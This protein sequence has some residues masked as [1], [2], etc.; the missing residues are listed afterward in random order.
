MVLVFVSI[1]QLSAAMGLTKQYLRFEAGPVFGVIGSRDC[2]ICWLEL[3]KVSRRYVAAAACEKVCVW[4]TVTGERLM[5]LHGGDSEVTCLAAH[6]ARALLAA[7][8][9]D[10]SV[11]LFSLSSGDLRVTL[12]GHRS[13]VSSVNFDSAGMRLVSGGKDNEIVVWD[14][15]V[16]AGLYRLLGHKGAVTQVRFMHQHNCLVSSSKDTY[17]KFWDLDNQHCFKTLAGHLTEVWDFVLTENDSRLVTGSGDAEL[18]VYTLQFTEGDDEPPAKAA[19]EAPADGDED[20]LE[21]DRSN[22]ECVRLGSIVRQGKGRVSRMVI[23]R[24]CRLVGFH[25]NDNTLELF[26]LNTEDDIA[27]RRQKRIKK[28]QKRAREAGKE[29]TPATQALQDELRRLPSIN[30]PSKVKAVDVSLDGQQAKLTVLLANNSLAVY[31][32]RVEA[33]SDGAVV[34][35]GSQLLLPGHRSE[36]RALD[37]S[38]DGTALLS[39]SSEQLKVWNRSTHQCIRTL[40]CDPALAALFVPGDRHVL[41]AGKSG[42][43]QLLELASGAL[44]ENVTAHG[45]EIWGMALTPDKRGFATA[46]AD[47]QV[48]LWRF[49]LVSTEQDRRRLSFLH[50]ASHTLSDDCL[51]I[52]FSPDGRLL[53]V[54]LLDSTVQIFFT[55]TMKLFLSLYGHRLPVLCMDISH[56]STLIA[57]GSGDRNVKIWGL[58]FGDCHKSL[59]AHDDSVTGLKFVPR[60]HHFFTCG[61]D[62]QVKEWDADSHQRIQTLQ[63][64]C[65]EVLALAVSP[66]GRHVLSSS[67]DRSLRLWQKTDEPLVLE[68]EREE[69]RAKEEERRLATGPAAAVPGETD[70]EAGRAGHKTADT[71]RAAE[72]L[73]EGITIYKQ[74]SR[75]LRQ[76]STAE[77]HPLMLAYGCSTPDAFMAEVLRRVKSSEL[78]ESL[79]VLPFSYVA[80]MLYILERLLAASGEVELVSRCLTFLLRVHHG[81]IVTNGVLA[82]VIERL[83]AAAGREI[84][85]LRDQIGFSRAGLEYLQRQLTERENISLFIDASERV[86]D[87]RKKRRR[88]ERTAQRAVLLM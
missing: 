69:E 17:V 81:Q 66:D 43:L 2:N 14:V 18:R 20:G 26:F 83:R 61:K 34:Q 67:R 48:K 57:T 35:P 30:C 15:V 38:S 51:S 24:H 7:G 9:A 36:V 50:T 31:D 42:R 4:D 70:R 75:A 40:D 63:G 53:A 73:M 72:R 77:L 85:Q 56:D 52:Q 60:T 37:F 78:E 88:R 71:E 3:N 33:R 54:A 41:V 39:A 10:G 28:E 55:D 16:E 86:K 29:A 8:C 65:R 47:K 44:L 68:E 49:E 59:F 58:D 21:S 13:A 6:P 25:G 46:S 1:L 79:L 87:K 11:R 32:V 45:G 74:M 80:D 12:T 5:V 62:G 23:D 19:R 27:R 82:P 76:S 22:L 84:G 64:H